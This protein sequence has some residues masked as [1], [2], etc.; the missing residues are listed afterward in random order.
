MNSFATPSLSELACTWFAPK[1]DVNTM[2]V[3]LKYTVSPLE[4]VK[5]PSSNICKKISKILGFGLAA[6]SI[7]SNNTTLN[8]VS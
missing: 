3:S 5:R 8:S 6:F 2:I 4:S 1:L 7:S